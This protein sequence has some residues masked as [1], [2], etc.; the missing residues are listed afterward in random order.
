MNYR[1]I[2]NGGWVFTREI[3]VMSVCTICTTFLTHLLPPSCLPPSLP[4]FPQKYKQGFI[5]DPVCM[6]PEN[7]LRDLLGLKKKY[8]FSG[9]P[10]TGE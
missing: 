4:L 10:V 3:T 7:T 8:G 9:I 5:V 2:K 6:G 1:V